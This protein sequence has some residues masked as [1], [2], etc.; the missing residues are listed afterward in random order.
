ML[1]AA[2]LLL[3]LTTQFRNGDTLEAVRFEGNR[4]FSA[5]VLADKVQSKRRKPGSESRMTRDAA[6]LEVFYHDQGFYAADVE[7]AVRPGRRRP[8]LVFIISEGPRARIDSVV[9][10]G[11]AAFADARLLAASGLKPGQPATGGAAPSGENGILALYHNSGYAFA[12][13]KGELARVDSSAVVRFALDEGPLCYVESVAFVGTVKVRA[14]TCRTIAEI[15]PGERYSRQ[16]L[17]DA[18]RRLYASKLFSRVGFSV[19]RADSA[20]DR[21]R[22]RFDVAEQPFRS[23]GLGGGGEINPGL[24]PLWLLL[25]LDW[26]HAN[27][28]GRNHTLLLS[29][30]YGQ[31]IIG[32]RFRVGSYAAWRIPYFGATRVDFQTRPFA[33]LERRDSTLLREYGVETGLSRSVLPQLTLGLANRLRLVADTSSGVTNSVALSGQY[34]SRN[35]I[36]EPSR[37][38]WVRGAAELAGGFLQGTNDFYRLSAD[39]RGYHGFGPGFVLAARIGAGRVY[40]YRPGELVAYYESFTLGG[41]ANLRGYPDRSIGPFGDSTARYGFAM[42]YGS[43]ELRTPYLFRLIGLAGF[44]EAGNL[45]RYFPPRDYL[46]S[47]GAG[48]RVKTPIGPVRLDWGK[49]LSAPAPG[50]IGRFHLGLLHAF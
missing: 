48:L 26:E 28:F 32:P 27:A 30:E 13:V 37:G 4:T 40:P 1:N 2:T 20:S 41:A 38:G 29:A 35:D 23:V 44:L 25:S 21:V 42:L 6:D 46:F 10:T 12:E 22:V 14:A 9:F 17:L 16:R 19:A 43:A 49:A 50:D 45:A 15:R 33:Y 5:R 31:Q 18:Q 47:A 3:L 24:T 34:D 36:F 8:V 11:N 39:V 7:R